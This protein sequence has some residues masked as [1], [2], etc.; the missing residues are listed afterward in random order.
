MPLFAIPE[1]NKDY[2]KTC[3]KCGQWFY[4]ST[5]YMCDNCRRKFE[6]EI[7]KNRKKWQEELKDEK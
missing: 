6:L 2:W 7:E 3:P 4:A 5:D 1:Q